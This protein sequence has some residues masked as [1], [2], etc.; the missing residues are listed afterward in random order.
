MTVILVVSQWQVHGFLGPNSSE[1]IALNQTITLFVRVE[2]G[3]T[4]ADMTL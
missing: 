2:A 4:N 3:A 1:C